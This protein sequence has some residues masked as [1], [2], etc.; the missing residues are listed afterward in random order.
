M[1]SQAGRR[2]SR[3]V[4]GSNGKRRKGVSHLRFSI[5]AA[6]WAA[7]VVL[8]GLAVPGSPHAQIR[9][10]DAEAVLTE[11]FGFSAAE[12]S[13]ARA[14]RAVAKL[15]P[16]RES[17]EV[18][19]AGSVH[20]TGTPDRLAYWLKDVGS[21]RNAAGLGI[22]KKLSSPPEVG[23]FADLA[24]SDEELKD[25]RAC[26][27]GNCDLRLGDSAISRFQTEVDW[28]APDAARRA[29]LLTRQLMLQHAEAY[30]RGGD[31]A[32]GALRDAKTSRVVTDEF[33]ALLSQATNLYELAPPLASYLEG[34]PAASLPG[35][36]S[37]STGPREE[38]GH[39][40]RSRCIS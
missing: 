2:T 10:T 26:R 17:T 33:H 15:L 7:T 12:I 30:L 36:S 4:S 18:G 5:R 6:R 16:S 13:E 24:L 39:S 8:S 34:Y 32:L 9:N 38:P 29:S 37:S 40:R 22:S 35:P 11:R 20:L 19:V 31:A 3:R 25:L 1:P 21:F 23:D 27:P 28:G 14:G